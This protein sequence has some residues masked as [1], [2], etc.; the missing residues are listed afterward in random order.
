MRHL[1]TNKREEKC[2]I[3]EFVRTEFNNHNEFLGRTI[4]NTF[5]IKSSATM[6]KVLLASFSDTFQFFFPPKTL[7]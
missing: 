5:E 4:D 1:C 2:K 7:M 6:L 3:T